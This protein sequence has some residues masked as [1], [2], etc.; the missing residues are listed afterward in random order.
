[1][2]ETA[3]TAS[4]PRRRPGRPTG[5]RTGRSPARDAILDAAR[6]RFA[7]HAYAD[8]TIRAVAA[9]AGVD[10][11][12]VLHHFGSKRQLFAAA[13][14]FPLHLR[15]QLAHLLR[16]DPADLGEQVVRLYLGMWQDPLTRAPLAAMIRSVLSDAEAAD[17]LG[18]FLSAEMIG[19]VVT[20]LGH[21]QPR[22]RISLTATHLL[23][24][25]IGRH[26]LAVTPLARADAEH[27]VACTAPVIQHYLTGPLPEAPAG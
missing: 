16:Q 22:L 13:L 19:P 10:P 24:L 4:G 12:L 20:A 2:N 26:L 1:M 6:N 14:R 3:P 18:Q 9:D 15:E 8:T 21:D 5:S 11:A 7:R 27:L 23:G 25:A 17:A